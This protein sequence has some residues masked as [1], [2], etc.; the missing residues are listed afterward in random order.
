MDQVISTLSGGQKKRLAL[1]I[2][3]LEKCDLLILDE[4]TNHL[5]I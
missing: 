4:P 2:V 3:L 1:A 5:D